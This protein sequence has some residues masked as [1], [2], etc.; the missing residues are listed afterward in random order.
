MQYQH[1]H[2]GFSSFPGNTNGYGQGK[3]RRPS[4]PASVSESVFHQRAR[5]P[6][7]ES[8]PEPEPEDG[9]EGEDDEEEEEESS[10]E[11]SVARVDKGKNKEDKDSSEAESPQES[12]SLHSSWEINVKDLVGDAV[13][14]VRALPTA[15]CF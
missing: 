1:Q 8:A 5:R 13:G 9:D 7:I 15:L 6:R 4:F 14:N 2:G 3:K 12:K 11:V 10:I